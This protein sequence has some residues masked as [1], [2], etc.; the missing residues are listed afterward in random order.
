MGKI[1]Y[2]SSPILSG[3]G[4]NIIIMKRSELKVGDKVKV[5]QSFEKLTGI[6]MP[7]QT[8]RKIEGEF[9]WSEYFAASRLTNLE[10]VIL[11]NKKEKLI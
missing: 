6:K 1:K 3:S 9:F 5:S 11:N 4:L 2:S 7:I 8:I 10:F